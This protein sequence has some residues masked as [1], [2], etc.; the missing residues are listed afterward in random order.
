VP[1]TDGSRASC[2]LGSG[3]AEGGF[4]Q[5]RV[6]AGTRAAGPTCPSK[7]EKRGAAIAVDTRA[8]QP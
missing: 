2:L 4:R 5:A 1:L 8:P 6:F 3:L 7:H